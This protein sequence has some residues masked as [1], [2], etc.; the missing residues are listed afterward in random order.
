MKA[1]IEQP[2]QSLLEKTKNILMGYG[3]L[4]VWTFVV[5]QIYKVVFP[6]PDYHSTPDL[7][8][9][10]QACFFAP[11]VEEFAFRKVP[12]DLIKKPDYA[13]YATFLILASSLLFGWLHFGVW[14]LPIQGVAGLVFA[15]LYLK[16]NF[17]YLS[18]VILHSMWNFSLISGLINF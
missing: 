15:Y 7:V 1:F 9:Y 14:S 6:A 18:S 5:S 8:D 3:F 16:N 17:S 13:S 12:L 2:A 11:F 4:I 10:L